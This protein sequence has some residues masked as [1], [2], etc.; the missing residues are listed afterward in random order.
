[1][2]KRTRQIKRIVLF[3]LLLTIFWTANAQDRLFTYTYQSTVLGK[4]QKELEVWNT[5]RTGRDDFY[6]RLDHR[7]EFEIGLGSNFQTAFY[8]NLTTKTQAAGPD[9]A[10]YLETE[11][12]IGF[13][14]EW[15][16]K[17]LDPVAHPVGLALY[18]EVG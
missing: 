1:M 10:K 2:M 3:A 12:E 17:L 8:L 4:G 18:A 14:N 7:T 6:A 15:K 13:S 5:F 16:F 9:S 11:N